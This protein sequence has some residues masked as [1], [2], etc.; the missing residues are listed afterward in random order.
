MIKE[1][2]IIRA[3]GKT[4]DRLPDDEAKVRVLDYI[5]ASLLARKTGNVDNE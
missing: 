5:R 4:L 1:L 3:I 2:V